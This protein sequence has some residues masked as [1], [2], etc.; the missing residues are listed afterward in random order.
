MDSKGRHAQSDP[1]DFGDAI[2]RQIIASATDYAVITVALD[3]RISTWSAGASNL[4]GYTSQEAVGQ[5]LAM[6][7]T[8]EDQLES[9]CHA[10]MHTALQYGRADDNRWH[11]RKDGSRLWA[12]GLL[13]LLKDDEQRAIGFVKILRDRTQYLEQDEAVR[14]SVERLRLI[15][16][17]ATDYA[18]LTFDQEGTLLTWNAGARR[19]LGY[20]EED[21]IGRDARVLFTPEEREAGALEWEMETATKEGRAENER[22]HVRKDG[23]RFWGSGL[24][25]PLMARQDKPGYLK[26]MRNDTERHLAEEHQQVMMREMSHRV[27][28]SL[29]LVTAMLAMQARV[30]DVPEVKRVLTDAETRVATIAAV[31]DHLWRQP[32][33]ETI[34]LAA[35]LKDL[36]SR[37]AQTSDRH[38]LSFDGTPCRIDTDRAIQAALIVN[39]L[40]TNAIKHA[41][42]SG[43]GR[44]DVL[45][46]TTDDM[47][48]LTVADDGVGLPTDFDLEGN[49]G[50]SLGMKVIRGLVRQLQAE[51]M[52][53]RTAPGTA[54]IAKIP[55]SS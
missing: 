20:T 1:S 16:E 54:L 53:I 37:L 2:Y 6:I 19:I 26:I 5:N 31:H 3:G 8:F 48:C 51:L 38:T 40:V 52:V 39:E 21:I 11:V 33:L 36:C 22:F 23:S 46:T 9:A 12:S 47:I 34:D 7:F 29:M 32:D 14:S 10:E 28:N 24:T 49:S 17:S 55:M 30:A 42:P 4:F 41:Y 35:F 15:L 44:I 27:K 50:R 13:M 25:M 45:I 43:G 18:I